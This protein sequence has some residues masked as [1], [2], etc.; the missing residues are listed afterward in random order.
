M[1]AP[2]YSP[3]RRVARAKKDLAKLDRRIRN[4]FKKQ[5]YSRVVEPDPE[6]AH[7]LH[8]IKLTKP[9]PEG[10]TDLTND[11]IEGLRSALDQ[12]TYSVA[13]ACSATQLDRVHFSI[14]DTSAD[15][16]NA[17]SGNCKDL[18]ADILALLRAFQPYKSGNDII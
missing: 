13:V 3:N 5:P 16:E 7:Q 18:P 9:L 8:K 10:F 15:F 14:F 2:F 12:A 4:F 1:T 6:S 11:I 17:L